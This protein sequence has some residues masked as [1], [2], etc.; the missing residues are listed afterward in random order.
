[1]SLPNA[2]KDISDNPAKG[3]V[4]D[5][6]DKEKQAADVDRKLR[7]YG[8]LNAFKE[9][10]MPSNEQIDRTLQYVETHSPIPEN[11][12]S[13]EGKKLIA[14]TRDIIETA[15]LIVKEKNQDE[16]FQN[17]IWHT[18]DTNL[19]RAKKDPNEVLPVDQQ[20]VRSDGQQAVA[21]LRT[22]LS[23]IFTNA[24]VRK[25]LSDFSVIGRDLFAR[26]AM[27]AAEKARPDEERL[28]TVDDT[29][30]NDTFY[31]EGGRTAGPDETPVSVASCSCSGPGT[32]LPTLGMARWLRFQPEC[33]TGLRPLFLLRWIKTDPNIPLMMRVLTTDS[34]GARGQG[35]WR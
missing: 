25:L 29:A 21:H 15:R 5:P 27:K 3:S 4:V 18:R 2:P 1:M 35:S 8:V 13:P 10:R 7:F 24:E 6:V 34:A 22:L 11:E 9:S 32:W 33:F 23:L 31:T 16:L 12:L 19:D 17:F 26:G 20:K 30:P 14:D 28:R